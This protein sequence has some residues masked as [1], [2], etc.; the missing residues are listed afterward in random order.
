M[1]GLQKCILARISRGLGSVL[2]NSV[3]ARVCCGNN[4]TDFLFINLLALLKGVKGSNYTCAMCNG[5]LFL[6]CCKYILIQYDL[7]SHICF[8]SGKFI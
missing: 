3:T 8:M 5:K 7:F 6:M 1:C 4:F 2:V